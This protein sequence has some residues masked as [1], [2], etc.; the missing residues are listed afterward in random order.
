MPRASA[1]RMTRCRWFIWRYDRKDGRCRGP[2][3]IHCLCKFASCV[4]L[5]LSPVFI[6][7]LSRIGLENDDVLVRLHIRPLNMGW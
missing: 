6:A 5:I 2:N 3:R 1:N 7:R 4:T